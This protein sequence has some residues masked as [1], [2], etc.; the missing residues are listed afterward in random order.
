MPRIENAHVAFIKR[1]LLP[2]LPECLFTKEDIQLIAHE[3]SLEEGQIQQWGRNFS[4]RF[5]PED[6][7]K[8]LHD[9][10]PEQVHCSQ[11]L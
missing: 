4:Q 5:A 8:A 1:T 2:R 10:N 3:T 11:S 6:R 7:E 9:Y